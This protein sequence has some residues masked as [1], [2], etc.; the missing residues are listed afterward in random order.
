MRPVSVTQGFICAEAAGRVARQ[1]VAAGVRTGQRMS[2]I[3]VRERDALPAYSAEIK[4]K[5]LVVGDVIQ[6]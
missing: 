6:T 3:G 1:L 4:T 5:E 2:I